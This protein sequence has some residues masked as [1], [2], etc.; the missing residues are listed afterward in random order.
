MPNYSLP[1]AIF[2]FVP[3]LLAAVAMCAL[4]RGISARHHALAPVAWAAALAIPLGGLCK[5]SWKLIVALK[6]T[7]VTWLD[8]LLFVLMA[9]GFV[10]LAFALFHARRAWQASV[11]PDRARY[12]LDRLLMWLILPAAGI[13]ATVLFSQSRGGFFWLLAV[14]T[15]ANAALIVH[16]MGASR[17]S[18]L[19]WH[20]AGCL[21][22][23]F[24][25]TLALAGLSRLTPGEHSAWIQEGVNLSAQ[26][27][28]LAGLWQ[29]ST[30]MVR[31]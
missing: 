25:A 4:A 6:Q 10:A 28:L 29:L 11:A 22:Y 17:W 8:D 15:V 18:R 30:R 9:P 20:V 13:A 1:V 16:A 21:A 3:V 12:P 31:S 23:A 7:D 14:T 24:A 5:A 2:D 27:A 26:L 19:P